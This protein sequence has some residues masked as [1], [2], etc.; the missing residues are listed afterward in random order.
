MRRV[1]ARLFEALVLALVSA[2]CGTP[3]GPRELGDL[4]PNDNNALF[5]TLV[6]PSWTWEEVTTAGVR[7][8]ITNGSDRTLASTLGDRFNSASEHA[9][10]YVALGGSGAV[11]W[12][13][14]SGTWREMGLAHLVE[15]VKQVML[16]PAGNYTLTALLREPRRTGT[17]R[18]RIDFVDAPAGTERHSDYSGVFEIR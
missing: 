16:R 12:R 10:L 2:T 11:E 15:G 1:Q 13:D 3:S 5:I 8:T 17:F 7:A 9:S 18:I 14:P 4:T 6:K